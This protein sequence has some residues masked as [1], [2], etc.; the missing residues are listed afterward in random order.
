M[1]RKSDIRLGQLLIQRQ[2]C[3]LQQVTEALANQAVQN[4]RQRNVAL[5]KLLLE[6]GYLEETRLMEALA[7]LG[8]LVLSCSQCGQDY[9]LS[10]YDPAAAYPCHKCGGTLAPEDAPKNVDALLPY[11]SSGSHSDLSSSTASDPTLRLNGGPVHQ[12]RAEEE[13]E[14]DPY[15]GRVLG[16]CK[17]IEKIAAGG[18][19]VVYKAQQLNLNRLVAVKVLSKALSSDESFVRRFIEEARSA[20][21]LSHGNIVH[22]NDVGDY[23]GIF[24]FTMEYVDGVNVKK[25]LQE[26]PWLPANRSVE[27]VL[28]VCYALQHAHSR[29][30]IHRDIKPENIMITRDGTVKLA[31]LGLA[32]QVATPGADSLTQAGSI[33][34]TPF[35]M[36]PEQAKDFSQVDARSDI[37]SLGVTLY[38]MISGKVPFTGRT[39]IEIMLRVVEGKRAPLR[40]LRP[41][42][43]PD[44][45]RVI[46]RMMQVHPARRYQAVGELIDDLVTVLKDLRE[47]QPQEDFAGD[48]S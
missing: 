27:I 32:K 37:Y 7:E 11:H 17:L 30:I 46:D 47:T 40:Q 20:A 29:G 48:L 45:E 43:P 41:D 33:L 28:Q 19:G 18:M 1:P 12:G 14:K 3:T 5:G 9:S 21:Q 6:C 39:P 13:P 35:Y 38:K 34:G 24:Y 42:V 16:G 2:W 25:L 10:E 26:H 44:V 36:A 23:Q 22:I 31:D 8:I 4:G 15:I